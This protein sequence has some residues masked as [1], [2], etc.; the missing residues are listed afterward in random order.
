MTRGLPPRVSARWPA[1]VPKRY[2]IQ[3]DVT[4]E[5]TD[6]GKVV[7]FLNPSGDRLFST[8]PMHG[9]DLYNQA[10]VFMMAANSLIAHEGHDPETEAVAKRLVAA[11]DDIE[12]VIADL[13]P[14]PAPRWHP[15][16][17]RSEE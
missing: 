3:V 4:V 9:A 15:G 14:E 16:R 7:R 8:T 1:N 6:E 11:M 13:P 17:R 10:I 12:D 2:T 5:A